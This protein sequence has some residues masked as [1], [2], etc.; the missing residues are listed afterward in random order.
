M[1]KTS[2][3]LAEYLVRK[4]IPFREAHGIVGCVVAYCEKQGNKLADVELSEFKK[5]CP[6]IKADVY[7][8]LGAANVVEQ[9]I[10]EGAAGPK[11]AKLQIAFWK[12]QL[13]KRG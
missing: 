8:S 12:K 3:A 10:T 5:Y 13:S 11:Q 4:G 6:A 1:W 7:K 9:Y 2:T